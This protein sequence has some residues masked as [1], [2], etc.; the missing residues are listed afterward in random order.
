MERK[1]WFLDE[2]KNVCD[3]CLRENLL[4]GDEYVNL[5]L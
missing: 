2:V 4:C 3:L 5:I 1:S